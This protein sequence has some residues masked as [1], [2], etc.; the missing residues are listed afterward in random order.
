MIKRIINSILLLFSSVGLLAAGIYFINP[1]SLNTF[2]QETEIIELQ[3]E[4]LVAEPVRIVIPRVGIDENIEE[5][6]KD[7]NGRMDVPKDYNNAGW[8]KYGAKPGEIGSAVLAGHIDTPFGER[9]I[10]YSL[11]DM[12]A[13]DLI[14]VYDTDNVEYQFEVTEIIE[15]E[16]DEFPLDLVFGRDDKKRLNLITCAGVYDISSG[17]YQERLVVYAQSLE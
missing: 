2:S 10:F 5:V 15:Y 7:E 17:N 16:D 12:S 8:W 3:T 13:G 6:G 1:V 9:G 11:G 4:R 14:L